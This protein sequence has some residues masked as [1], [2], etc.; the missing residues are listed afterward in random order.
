M[1]N[2]KDYIA[3]TNNTTIETVTICYS[4]LNNEF[5]SILV[6]KKENLAS[7]KYMLLRKG[8]TI[9]GIR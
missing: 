6:C 5:S 3:L 2:L 4:E 1:N 7:A 9:E 8:A